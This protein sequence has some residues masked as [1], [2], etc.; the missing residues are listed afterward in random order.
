MS[1]PLVS[2][3]CPVHNEEPVLEELL[4]RMIRALVGLEDQYAFEIILVDDG[5]EDGSIAVMKQVAGWEARL[6]IIELR[7]R[8]ALASS[9]SMWWRRNS[10]RWSASWVR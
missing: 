4:Q 7:R 3:I 10:A 8:Y 1:K 2:I 5:S 6:R 9:R